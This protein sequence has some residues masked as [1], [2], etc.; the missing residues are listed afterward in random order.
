MVDMTRPP[1]IRISTLSLGYILIANELGFQGRNLWIILI[2][3]KG[4]VIDHVS[5][6]NSTDKLD[7]IER[8]LVE[9]WPRR[10]SPTLKGLLS[11]NLVI[12]YT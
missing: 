6:I 5:S 7:G 8:G 1:A 3:R 2:V 4:S 10:S 11:G 12:C 9:Y